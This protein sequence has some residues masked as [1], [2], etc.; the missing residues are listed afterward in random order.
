MRDNPRFKPQE[1]NCVA[2]K[3]FIQVDNPYTSQWTDEDNSKYKYLS[4]PH[5]HNKVRHGTK[6]YRSTKVLGEIFDMLS[7][8]GDFKIDFNT[9]V[10]PEMNIHIRRRVERAKRNNSEQ[11][12][13]I[14]KDMLAHLK[15][16]NCEVRD[17]IKPVRDLYKQHRLEIEGKYG[18]ESLFDLLDVFAILYAVTYFESRERVQRFKREPYVFAWEVSHDYLTRIFGD[19]NSF[20]GIALTVARGHDSRIFGR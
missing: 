1:V 2:T 17:K 15:R 11:F 18:D 20:G 3:A 4:K 12:E 5:W 14:H 8:V 9:N 19:G 10:E 13:A 6:T 16:F 7:G